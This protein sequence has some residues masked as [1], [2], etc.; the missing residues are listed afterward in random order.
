MLHEVTNKGRRIVMKFLSSDDNLRRWTR[1]AASVSFS[2]TSAW[3]RGGSP[4]HGL[5]FL[6]S[7][8]IPRL[9]CLARPAREIYCSQC[10][11]HNFSEARGRSNPN[12]YLESMDKNVV[13]N[14]QPHPHIPPIIIASVL[15]LKTNIFLLMMV[16]TW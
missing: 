1:A 9:L 6:P 11:L 4:T 13:N 8:I 15:L 2:G 3:G 16:L 7:Y 10:L 14:T 12:P 5:R